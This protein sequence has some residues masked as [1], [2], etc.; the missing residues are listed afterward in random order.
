MI[1]RQC[2]QLKLSARWRRLLEGR[3]RVTSAKSINDVALSEAEPELS[4]A[5]TLDHFSLTTFECSWSAGGICI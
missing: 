2:F 3:P 5:N 4:H 1:E